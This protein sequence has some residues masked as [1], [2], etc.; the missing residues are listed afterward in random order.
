MPSPTVLAGALLAFAFV[1]YALEVLGLQRFSSFAYRFGLRACKTEEAC[2]LPTW[3]SPGVTGETE[4]ASYRIDEDGRCLFWRN[5]VLQTGLRFVP[6]GTAEIKGTITWADGRTKTTGRYLFAPLVA[7][8]CGNVVVSLFP[9][10][11][12]LGDTD[13]TV[14][15]LVLADAAVVWYLLRGAPRWFNRRA[16][17][18]RAALGVPTDA[19][20]IA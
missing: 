6:T 1:V 4:H 17:E 13:V 12:L 19:S 8:I 11:S 10:G 9:I 2:P 5:S 7:L 14:P 3:L 16:M 15:F 18:V 20:E